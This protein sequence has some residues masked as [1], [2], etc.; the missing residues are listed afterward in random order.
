MRRGQ[1]SA[2]LV[3]LAGLGFSGCTKGQIS[4]ALSSANLERSIQNQ[5]ST[6]PD[7]SQLRVS[8]DASRNQATIAG[9]VA[10]EAQHSK[11]LEIA[12]GAYPGIAITDNIEV[13]ASGQ[14]P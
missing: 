7:L 1:V 13:A 5:W 9:T 14:K 8:A 12:K 10:T 11:A 4:T 2:A 3:L 6:H